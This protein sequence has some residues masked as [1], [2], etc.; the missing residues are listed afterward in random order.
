MSFDFQ[1]KNMA[2]NIPVFERAK[3]THLCYLNNFRADFSQ[4]SK[5]YLTARKNL[6]KRLTFE[7]PTR[8]SE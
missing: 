7:S 8:Q 6:V 3:E 2:Y 4:K 1:E 5:G